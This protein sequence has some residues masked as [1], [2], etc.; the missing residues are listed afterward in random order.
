V[1]KAIVNPHQ[2]KLSAFLFYV[3]PDAGNGRGCGLGKNWNRQAQHHVHHAWLCRW[4]NLIDENAISN[5]A[6]HRRLT[7][8]ETNHLHCCGSDGRNRRTNHE[9]IRV[10]ELVVAILLIPGVGRI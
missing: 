4:R 8:N 2:N 7:Q 9:L 3:E 6:A 10:R 1:A 5:L